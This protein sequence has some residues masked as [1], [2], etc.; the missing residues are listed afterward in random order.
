M[1]RLIYTAMNGARTVLWRQAVNNHNLA[2]LDTTGFRA[3]LA[4]QQGWLLRG[5]GYAARAVGDGRWLGF[6]A[7]PGR[8]QHT[9][10]DLDVAVAG[11]GYLAVQTPEG[12]EAYTR[13]GAL[14][15]DAAGVLRTAEGWAVLGDGGPIA[16]PPFES[17]E[18]GADGTVSV[19]PAGQGAATLAAVAR[20][21]LVA[22][23]DGELVKRPDGLLEHPAGV[24]PADAGVRLV[25]GALESSNVNAVDALVTMIDLSRQFELGVKVLERAEEMDRASAALMRLR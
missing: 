23:P 22:P 20:I 3:D 2:N 13:A 14:R 16:L 25:S 8:L 9:G 1:D 17:V 19:R 18:I 6:D 12:G 5:A 7:T 15:V 21:K 4:A 11:R 24:Q 10:R